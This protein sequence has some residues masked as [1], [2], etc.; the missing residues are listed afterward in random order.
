L[1]RAAAAQGHE[2]RGPVR[3]KLK[4]P[5]IFN[6]LGP[7][8]NPARTSLQLLGVGRDALRPVMAEA[9]RLLGIRRAVVVFGSDGLDEVTLGGATHVTE[10]AGALVRQFDWTPADFDLEP[11]DREALLVEGPQ[12]SAA[13]IRGIL[14][15]RPGPPRD[16]VVANAAAAL[17][18]AGLVATPAEGAQAAGEAIS[19]GAARELLA[20]LAERTGG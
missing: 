9:L 11:V 8:A 19:S 15:D 6:I 13:V 7:L 5:T 20:R 2:A 1:L 17:W 14:D 3:K 4:I 18:T 16:I 10:V 12:Q